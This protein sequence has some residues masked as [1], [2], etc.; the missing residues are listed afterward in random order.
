MSDGLETSKPWERQPDEPSDS[1]AIF[2]S[3]ADQGPDRTISVLAQKTGSTESSLRKLSARWGWEKRAQEWDGFKEREYLRGVQ[4]GIREAA[5]RHRLAA[6]GMLDV[7][8]QP[9]AELSRR[10]QAR[11]GLDWNGVP[12]AY[13]VKA[14][15]E[16]AGALQAL[17]AIE[18]LAI[19]ADDVPKPGQAR[20]AR[21]EVEKAGTVLQAVQVIFQQAA[22]KT[23]DVP[24]PNGHAPDGGTHK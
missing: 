13:L 15:R 18:R 20:G 10:M 16:S 7:L 2:R 9:V 14:V 3:Y 17:V 12:D 6:R 24:A 5:G 19:G 11:G 22:A 4:D 21:P 1:F 23:L 8:M